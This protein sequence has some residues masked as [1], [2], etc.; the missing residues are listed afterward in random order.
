P[1]TGLDDADPV[2]LLGQ[3]QRGHRAAEARADDED[4]V[5][6]PCPVVGRGAPAGRARR[7]H[8]AR[9]IFF[10]SRRLAVITLPSR[11]SESPYDGA[12]RISRW[13]A[14]D[15][16]SVYR[17][18]PSAPWRRPRPDCRIPPIGASRLPKVAAKASLMLTV[19]HLIWRAIA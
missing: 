5:V 11:S 16:V 15:C 6:E 2:A 7:D 17:S 14:T 19:P 18:S 13:V 9:P 10:R 4:V 12:I 1:R 8:Q 3:P